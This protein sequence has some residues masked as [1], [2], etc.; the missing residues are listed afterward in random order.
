MARKTKREIIEETIKYY[1]K[2]PRPVTESGDCYYFKPQDPSCMCA[3]GRCL[4]RRNLKVMDM[5]M[6]AKGGSAEVM[7]VDQLDE[8]LGGL[9]AG[10]KPAY[11]GHPQQ[12]WMDLQGFHDSDRNWQEGGLTSTGQVEANILFR[13]HD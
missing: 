3:V 1:S 12:F 5:V 2:H 10:F 7:G 6:D 9:E 11:K 13:K 4:T 8:V